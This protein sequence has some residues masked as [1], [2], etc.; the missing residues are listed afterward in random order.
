MVLLAVLLCKREK[1]SSI[2]SEN[3]RVYRSEIR[4]RNADKMNSNSPA[5]ADKNMGTW[6]Y[7]VRGI[8]LLI[9][10][11]CILISCTSPTGTQSITPQASTRPANHTPTP[12]PPT[13]TATPPQTT[14][15]FE[16]TT[17]DSGRTV[18]YAITSRFMI[19]F[20]PQKYPKKNIQV[21][22]LPQDT[23]GNIEDLPYI[24]P[25][26][27]AVRYEGTKPGVCTITNGNFR[28]TVRIIYR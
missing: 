17:Q 7:Y 26:L 19:T 27:Y 23:I 16:F 3:I 28:L 13:P 24:P 18:T 15:Q 22:C 12:L 5:S 1:V 11:S 2:S 9:G 6:H 10:I 8:L 4:E 21:S 14:Q 20:D 25:P